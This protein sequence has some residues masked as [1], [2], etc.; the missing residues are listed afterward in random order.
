[1]VEELAAAR[2][3][4]HERVAL[5]VRMRQRQRALRRDLARPPTALASPPP[6]RTSTD[7]NF[8][9]KSTIERRGL[10]YEL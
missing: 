7:F 5:G 1:M 8:T 9:L 2:R 6:P 4:H 10:D 3:L